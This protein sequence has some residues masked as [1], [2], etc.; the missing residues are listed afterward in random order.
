MLCVQLLEISLKILFRINIT[1]LNNIKHRNQVLIYNIINRHERK[2]YKHK[3]FKIKLEIAR[4]FCFFFAEI[5]EMF[6]NVVLW[7]LT[8]YV[9]PKLYLFRSISYGVW[10]YKIEF[11]FQKVILFKWPPFGQFLP[12]F[13]LKLITT[14]FQYSGCS[15]RNRFIKLFG[16]Y[17]GQV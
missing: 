17:H 8:R 1:I 3:D 10:G 9:I 14:S 15:Y 6:K 13:C 5:F 16:L 7:S 11:K 4:Y 12:D 2:K